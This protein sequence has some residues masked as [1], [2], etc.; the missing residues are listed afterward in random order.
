[1]LHCSV[2]RRSENKEFVHALSEL[3]YMRSRHNVEFDPFSVADNIQMLMAV[4]LEEVRRPYVL[5]DLKWGREDVKAE[6]VENFGRAPQ[7]TDSVTDYIDA[8]KTRGF[9]DQEMVA[10]SYV[11]AFGEVHHPNQ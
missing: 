3:Q 4:G 6:D 8:F 11:H 5:G 9:T 1:M 7:P 2:A 10:L